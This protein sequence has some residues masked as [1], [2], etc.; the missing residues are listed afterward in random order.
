[1]TIFYHMGEGVFKNL[2][3]DEIKVFSSMKKYLS[4]DEIYKN[5]L[6]DRSVVVTKENS[7]E[8]LDSGSSGCTC[9]CKD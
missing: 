6:E 4:I 8:L 5:F 3:K 2:I 7:S 9:G 1:M